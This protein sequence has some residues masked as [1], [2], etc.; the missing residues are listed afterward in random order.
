[1]KN[2]YGNYCDR[3]FELGEKNKCLHMPALPRK[4]YFDLALLPGAIDFLYGKTPS[5]PF[6]YDSEPDAKQYIGYPYL[7]VKCDDKKTVEAPLL[8]FPIS[9]SDGRIEGAGAPFP[10]RALFL[11]TE[12]NRRKKLFAA[13]ESAD[14]LSANI[15][16]DL[17]EECGFP[18]ER[19]KNNELIAFSDAEAKKKRPQIKNVAVLGP[20]PAMTEMQEDYY[21]L[22]KK[23]VCNA[24]LQQLLTGKTKKVRA[25]KNKIYLTEELDS[26]QKK[27]VFSD[28]KNIA[29]FG[30]P[31]TGKSQTI[32]AV[33]GNNLA[34]GKK[35]LVVCQKKIALEVIFARLK[36]LGNKCF[37]C[38]DPKKDAS[39]FFG[40]LSASYT[41]ATEFEDEASEKEYIK[42]G[43]E[44][45]KE[46]ELLEKIN[47][48]LQK[49]L[50]YGP[51]LRETYE[52]SCKNPET[53]QERKL[54]DDFKKTGACNE[55]YEKLS[56][57]VN[58]I[59]N[60][61]LTEKF[62]EYQAILK[63][64]D[65]ACHVQE[66]DVRLL[67]EVKE[68]CKTKFDPFPFSETPY[69]RYLLPFFLDETSE[70]AAGSALF[71][72][73]HPFLKSMMFLSAFPL[74]WPIFAIS[75]KH[76]SATSSCVQ[77]FYEK[78]GKYVSSFEPL[79]RFYDKEGYEKV[80]CALSFGADPMPQIE[81]TVDNY[82]AVRALKNV[83]FDI[84]P[85]IKSL[86][87]FIYEHSG[88]TVE[89]M[90]ETLDK[91][92]SLRAYYELIRNEPQA[93]KSLSL[94]KRYDEIVNHILALQKKAAMIGRMVALKKCNDKYLSF[95][96][97][98]GADKR[99]EF[100][101]IMN[102]RNKSIRECYCRF[103]GFVMN[104]LPCLLT[105]PETASK[106]LPLQKDMFD[107]VIFDEASQ[108]PVEN[109][110]PSL[111][112]GKTAVISGDD[113]QLAPADSF[114]RKHSESEE[115]IP[116][117]V[118]KARSL[119][120]LAV[121]VFTTVKLKY[122]YRSAW[123]DLID[124]SNRTFYDQEL[125]VAPDPSLPTEPPVEYVKINGKRTARKNKREADEIV[126]LAN[127]YCKYYSIGII[128]LNAEQCELI[129]EKIEKKL[130]TDPDF[131]NHWDGFVK[132]I[133]NVQ[134]EE[135][136]V[137]L[138]SVGYAPN[139]NGRFFARYGALGVAGGEKRLNVAVTRAVKKMVVVTS[140]EPEQL[141]TDSVKNDGPKLLKK[142]LEYAKNV[143]RTQNIDKNNADVDV[144]ENE[145][146]IANKL[147]EIGY[148]VR[149][150]AGTKKREFS[151][152]VYD[153]DR[154]KFLLGVE[155]DER[156]YKN[157]NT[158][159]DRDVDRPNFLRRMGWKTMRVWTRDF[160]L[161][162]ANVLSDVCMRL[163]KERE[164]ENLCV[165]F[166]D[167]LSLAS[168]R[169]ITEYGTGEIG[170]KCVF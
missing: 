108:I 10:N 96:S 132:S 34:N 146:W 116:E 110:V 114:I 133:E 90:N 6:P 157:G 13:L 153:R 27:A 159:F 92:L 106:I 55:T 33:V 63:N 14:D 78:Y 124:F 121:T 169:K 148:D 86:L 137:I 88:K 49:K 158:V 75:R 32:A 154:N 36:E 170:E 149:Y 19:P 161:S 22:Q 8:F 20:F 119:L 38:V 115:N 30:P 83:F 112:R 59:K 1:M 152:A 45:Q 65:L 123:R 62:I 113:K 64:N 60:G 42:C 69:G 41:Q 93:E 29:L 162:P 151:F 39:A 18:F 128:T 135:K 70:R 142:F 85:E 84:A 58:V 57:A 46:Y 122:H 107:V 43:S 167:P 44:L 120:D 117:S 165:R 71:S 160:W 15:F 118:Q 25:Q 81:K 111:Y 139:E 35:V 80:V 140:I 12:K 53:E 73:L 79:K 164:K 145:K 31:G 48:T 9:A 16:L 87:V 40:A 3:L 21:T 11:L 150:P 7:F 105:T 24:A 50:P 129:N 144:T 4:K 168:E 23:N 47:E 136:D 72:H 68:L 125:F 76:K 26:S 82:V 155:T 61:K 109:A 67:G 28:D 102:N 103:G 126:R 91:V 100:L 89:S 99:K 147:S 54:I 51:T 74:F 134:G 37:L 104:L 5:F 77:L 138:L 156:A 101:F 141:P 2:V 127:K 52:L 131:K 98:F 163:E 166:S 143:S 130:K 94:T 95:H 97:S 56:Y 17:I 66:A